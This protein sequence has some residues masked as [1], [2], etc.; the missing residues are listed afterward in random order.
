[1]PGHRFKTTKWTLISSVSV[2]DDRG[3]KALEELCD[4]YWRPVYGFIR[5]QGYAADRAAD[6]TQGVFVHLLRHRGFE[7]ADPALGR[8]RSYL[9]TTVRHFLINAHA[10]DVAER[11]GRS[12]VHQSIDALDAERHFTLEAAAAQASPEA[13]FER[14]WAVTTTERAMARLAQEYEA[15][16]QRA[17]FDELQS[18]LTSDGVGTTAADAMRDEAVGGASATTSKSDDARRTALSRLRRRFAHALRAEI[19]ETVADPRDVDDELRHLLQ[20][21]ANT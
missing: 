18:D 12:V 13:A 14:Q 2:D 19:A 9:L 6:L 5:R 21:L 20:A 11:R 8:F 10:Y 3:R 1:M 4:V 16:G 7:R 17:I 15:R